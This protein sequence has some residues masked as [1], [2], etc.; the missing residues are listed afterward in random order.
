MNGK[1][2]RDGHR[3][4]WLEQKERIE[5]PKLEGPEQEPPKARGRTQRNWGGTEKEKGEKFQLEK[6]EQGKGG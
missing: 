3:G 1:Q 5:H 6:K 4:Q 2:G